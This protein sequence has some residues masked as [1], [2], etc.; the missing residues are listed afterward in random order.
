MAAA[1]GVFGALS[2]PDEFEAGISVRRADEGEVE[3]PSSFI[4]TAATIRVSSL[5]STSSPLSLRPWV[6]LIP[7]VWP[8]FMKFQVQSPASVSRKDRWRREWR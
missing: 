6:P 4:S 2:V 3:L 8:A 1:A 5:V 7:L